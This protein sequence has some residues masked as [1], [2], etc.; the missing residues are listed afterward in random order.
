[1]TTRKSS[2]G[3]TLL[4]VLMVVG[5]FSLILGLVLGVFLTGQLAWGRGQTQIGLQQQVRWGMEAMVRELNLSSQSRLRIINPNRLTFQG[6][7][8]A[9]NPGGDSRSRIDIDNHGNL[10]WG[11]DATPNN[12]I[13]Y[14]VVNNELRRRVVPAVGAAFISETTLARHIQSVTFLPDQASDSPTSPDGIEIILTGANNNSTCT[15]IT[16]IFCKN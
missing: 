6:P 8:N 10:V 3:F 4:E 2:A 5:L 7:L 14:I 11:A 13:E 16:M 12:W 9:A 15:L 1:M